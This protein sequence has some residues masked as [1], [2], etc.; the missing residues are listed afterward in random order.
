MP[1]IHCIFPSGS[2][3]SL[4]PWHAPF[5]LSFDDPKYCLKLQASGLR[6]ET[7][8]S[9]ADLLPANPSDCI[10]DVFSPTQWDQATR[11]LDSYRNAFTHFNWM[12][13]GSSSNAP[14][15]G[16]QITGEINTLGAALEAWG[17][18][19]VAGGVQVLPLDDIAA[20]IEQFGHQ[21]GA[22]ARP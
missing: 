17:F 19:A 2:A 21:A 3:F 18:S 11:C 16:A 4:T 6:L 5:E 1:G 7:A 9:L 15:S 12:V 10:P 8:D 22:A 20:L 13:A 14:F